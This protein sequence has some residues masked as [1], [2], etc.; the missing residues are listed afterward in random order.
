MNATVEK[1]LR[2]KY[3]AFSKGIQQKDLRSFTSILRNK[4][5]LNVALGNEQLE[6]FRD[7][8][9]VEL[10]S[11]NDAG[12]IFRMAE[13]NLPREFW[14]TLLIT[15][16]KDHGGVEGVRRRLK[17]YGFDH[18][19][20]GDKAD[21]LAEIELLALE[22]PPF[23]A[24]LDWAGQIEGI[25][26][27]GD[28]DKEIRY[29]PPL[30]VRQTMPV[31]PV[32]ALKACMIKGKKLDFDPNGI[33]RGAVTVGVIDS[34]IDPGHDALSDKIV[35]HVDICGYGMGAVDPQGH[36]THVAGI[37]A[38]DWRR[39]NPEWGGVSPFV[40]L[41]DIQ[42]WDPFGVTAMDFFQAI[43]YA[44]QSGVDIVNVSMGWDMPADGKS[45]AT[46]VIERASSRGVLVCV[47]AG[48]SGDRGEPAIAVPGDAPSAI[49]V[50][51]VDSTGI[52]APLSSLGPALNPDYSGQ[53]PTV[54]APGIEIVSTRSRCSHVQPHGSAT[55]YC[56]MSGTSMATPMMTGF[57]AL[58]IGYLKRK[59]MDTL[60][61][62]TVQQALR[63]S[64]QN[65]EQQ[66]IDK[67]GYGIPQLEHF[68]EEL[69]SSLCASKPA[70]RKG[71]VAGAGIAEGKGLMDSSSVNVA[72]ESTA[73]DNMDASGHLSS[74]RSMPVA[75]YRD[76]ETAFLEG[77][78]NNIEQYFTAFAREELKLRGVELGERRDSSESNWIHDLAS[79]HDISP[80]DLESGPGNMGFQV[81]VLKRKRP[82]ASLVVKS[83]AAWEAYRQVLGALNSNRVMEF[84]R[85]NR[86]KYKKG[87]YFS[88]FTPGKFPNHVEQIAADGAHSKVLFCNPENIGEKG[89]WYNIAGKDCSWAE[90]S[91]LTPMKSGLRRDRVLNTLL[92]NEDLKIP[93]EVIRLVDLAESLQLPAG[94]AGRACRL[95]AG[96]GE[97]R[98][99][100]EPSLKNIKYVKRVKMR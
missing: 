49:T 26:I 97:K 7:L 32:E 65:K 99:S 74:A 62:K 91:M 38:G 28:G 59:G 82:I 9:A 42:L 37:I 79:V 77:V 15:C 54:V 90:W 31:G 10:S 81:E 3:S 73:K 21:Y 50:A 72:S 80:Q 45:Q 70:P 24:I 56:S 43:G 35:D 63:K 48:N 41:L 12:R 39:G 86:Q 40:D 96:A 61:P 71:G 85:L 78:W 95:I 89:S 94:V 11:P 55:D 20:I 87:T 84:I 53:K 92:D 76:M 98:F 52:H 51:A 30:M 93:G 44:V 5:A 23:P 83:F 68:I 34:G 100:F 14:N 6:L 2:D 17:G 47:A 22:V 19:P 27:L 46:D 58:G 29:E 33:K 36:G 16:K 60:D 25:D 67:V 66:N 13:Q 69:E 64:A 88:I 57:C 4:D 1:S 18:K 75:A 8:N